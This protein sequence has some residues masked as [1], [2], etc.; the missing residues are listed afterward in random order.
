MTFLSSRYVVPVTLAVS[1]GKLLCTARG[2][3][4][5]SLEDSLN[6]RYKCGGI[7]FV[8]GKCYWI[9]DANGCGKTGSY[10]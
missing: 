10:Q 9:S 5:Q 2:E 6:T 1:L 3:E 7:N 4:T 8:D